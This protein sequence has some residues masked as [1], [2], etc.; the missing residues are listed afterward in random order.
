LIETKITCDYCKGEVKKTS[1][2]P[3]TTAFWQCAPVMAAPEK[4]MFA[5]QKVRE[6]DEHICA[7]CYNEM[8]NDYK[9]KT[10]IIK[11]ESNGN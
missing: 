5:I 11:R 9:V 1:P 3:N 2:Y 6:G 8:R 10:G 7:G 4:T